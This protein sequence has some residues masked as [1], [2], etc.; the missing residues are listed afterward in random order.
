MSHSVE[1]MV[2]ERDGL[3]ERWFGREILCL[4]QHHCNA[5]QILRLDQNSWTLSTFWAVRR[6]WSIWSV[7]VQINQ[8][9]TA[10]WTA[11]TTIVYI[12]N[13]PQQYTIQSLDITH[14]VF[15]QQTIVAKKKRK[16]EKKRIEL[17]QWKANASF[18]HASKKQ[19]FHIEITSAS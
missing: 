6:L 18:P 17:Y 2:R 15:S 1:K 5:T 19:Q 4:H 14:Q 3:G 11:R 8:P 9:K 7:A 16:G 12:P 13:W 10:P